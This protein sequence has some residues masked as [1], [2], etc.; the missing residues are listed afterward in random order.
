MKPKFF[1]DLHCHCSIK[2]FARSYKSSAGK[3][4]LSASDPSS[5]WHSDKPTTFDKIKN[6]LVG[7]TNFVQ[8]DASSLLQGHVSI[9]FLSIY[10]QEKSFFKNKWGTGISSDLGSRLATEF[11]QQKIDAIQSCE[12]YWEELKLEM[13]YLKQGANKPLEI[14]GKTSTYKI[15]QGYSDIG[16][17]IQ[18][19]KLGETLNIFL[20]TIEGCHV[21]DQVMS[22][23][24]AWD[25]F[26]DGFQPQQLPFVLQRVKELRVGSDKLLRPVFVT[27]TH[28][29]WNGLCGQERSLGGLVG[30]VVNQEN[31]LLKGIS[32]SG[33]LVLKALLEEQ[34]ENGVTIP[35]IY[36]D[37]K[38]M[39]RLSREQYYDL[40]KTDYKN[41]KIPVIASHAGVTGLEK[42][43]GK[44]LTPIAVEGLFLAD[45]INIF[46]DEL[47]II[48]ETG[49]LFGIQLDER[50]IGSKLALSTTEHHIAQKGILYA[51]AGLVWNQIQHVAEVLDAHQKFS[52]GIQSIGSDFDGIID[53][54]NGYWT[55]A[56]MNDLYENLLIYAKNYLSGPVKCPLVY[57]FN[58]TVDADEIIGRVMTNN[59]LAFL[60]KFYK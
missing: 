37:V 2:G 10:T 57:K 12:S 30:C 8:S 39:S 20:P 13:S 1:V 6:Y 24:E 59:A 44:A 32:K 16:Q 29:F 40:L 42:P 4:G 34:V 58:T 50:R 45:S 52:W 36:I 15:A 3:Q 17:A 53:P 48:E 38:H 27:F 19:G 51:R 41:Q 11:G 46:D 47:L 7:L 54:I 33:K 25:D 14:N 56:S 35:P 31:G 26:S 9:V 49:G 28:H 43:G 18:S 22:S 55:S 60:S 21:F 23:D 5:I